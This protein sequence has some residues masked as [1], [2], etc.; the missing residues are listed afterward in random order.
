M[1]IGLPTHTQP[2]THITS[3]FPTACGIGAQKSMKLCV[4]CSTLALCLVVSKST[5]RAADT[6]ACSGQISPD[7]MSFLFRICFSWQ[8]TRTPTPK[9]KNGAC[10]TTLTGINVNGT[11]NQHISPTTGLNWSSYCRRRFSTTRF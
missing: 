7:M 2:H 4:F 9:R 1:R 8:A 6:A 10:S 11:R 3:R 5:A